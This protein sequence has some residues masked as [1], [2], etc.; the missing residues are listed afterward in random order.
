MFINSCKQHQI[1]IAILNET[2]IK[3]T[4]AAV[5]QIEYKCK[6]IGKETWIKGVDSKEQEVTNNTY[7][8]GGVMTMITGKCQV[9]VEEKGVES[10]PLGNWIATKLHY[11]KKIITLINVY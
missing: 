7:L 5:D 1:D 6:E 3:W 11:K 10:S 2:N 9:L 4:P 8:P